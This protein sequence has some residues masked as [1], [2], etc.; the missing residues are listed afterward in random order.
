MTRVATAQIFHLTS[1]R[2]RAQRLNKT[3]LCCNLS[4]EL[5]QWFPELFRCG[6]SYAP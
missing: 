4:T 2:P 5:A 6:L 3:N 1:V